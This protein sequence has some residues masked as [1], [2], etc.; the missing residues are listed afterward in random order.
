MLVPWEWRHHIPWKHQEPLTKNTPSQHRRLESSVTRCILS[1]VCQRSAYEYHFLPTPTFFLR[2]ER[3]QVSKMLCFVWN[4][5]QWM[6]CKNQITLSTIQTIFTILYNWIILDLHSSDSGRNRLV[7][8]D[9]SGQP[10]G[11]ILKRQA[12]TRYMAIFLYQHVLT[13]TTSREG[14]L[15]PHE[16]VTGCN[17][18]SCWMFWLKQTSQCPH[19]Q[20]NQR[21]QVL[22]SEQ[23]QFLPVTHFKIR[24]C[25]IFWWERQRCLWKFGLLTPNDMAGHLRVLSLVLIMKLHVPYHI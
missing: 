7:A 8:N 4:I 24:R 18:G 15:V 14:T 1:W 6:K 19:W 3:E 5:R 21:G 9:V 25:T 22:R 10:F 12:V 20:P 13:L 17:T 2:T 23:L 11:C 16:Q